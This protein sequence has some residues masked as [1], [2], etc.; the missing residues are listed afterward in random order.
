M[1]GVLVSFA[2]PKSDAVGSAQCVELSSGGEGGPKQFVYFWERDNVHRLLDKLRGKYEIIVWSSL[3]PALTDLI[4]AHIER[5]KSY[6]ALVLS[7]AQCLS[8]D[9]RKPTNLVMAQATLSVGKKGDQKKALEMSFSSINKSLYPG[10]LLKDMSMLL[11]NR[12]RDSII[13][14]DCTDNALWYMANNK[15][16]V[17]ICKKKASLQLFSSNNIAA[18]EDYKEEHANKKHQKDNK[19]H[20][21]H[22]GNDSSNSSDSESESDSDSDEEDEEGNDALF[23][24][25]HSILKN[26]D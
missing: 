26:T 21:S 15:I 4:V 7:K 3:G 12:S 22:N 23:K 13:V 24:M 18:L 8:F 2:D 5:D 16:M 6:F 19:D 25:I 20:S 9:T 1:P 17:G 10:G 11:K 14:M